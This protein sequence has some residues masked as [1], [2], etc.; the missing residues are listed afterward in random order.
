MKGIRPHKGIIIKQ[1]DNQNIMIVHDGSFKF[2]PISESGMGYENVGKRQAI[3]IVCKFY[4][5]TEQISLETAHNND[6]EDVFFMIRE[7][8]RLK[9]NVETSVYDHII[10]DTSRLFDIWEAQKSIYL[11]Q[12]AFDN[13]EKFRDEDSWAKKLHTE[14]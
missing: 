9:I 10:E 8:G 6:Y 3:A 1:S 14:Q 5:G 7:F 13:Y 11:N 4:D 2:I 12:E